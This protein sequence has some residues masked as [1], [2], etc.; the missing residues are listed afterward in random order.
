MPWPFVL[1]CIKDK[2][3]A[4]IPDT[5]PSFTRSEVLR[6]QLFWTMSF[7]FAASALAVSALVV[8]MT[9]LLHDA[10]LGMAAVAKI[11]SSI[12]LGVLGGRIVVGYLIDRFFAPYVAA[13]LFAAT[14][15]G[16]TLLLLSGVSVAPFAGMLMGLSLGAEVDLIAY[17]TSRYF[18]MRRYGFVY[19]VS[20]SIY[21]IGAS[22]GPTL[23]GI[24]FDK[25][26]SYNSVLVGATILLI[27][28]AVAML[29]MPRFE[30]ILG[31]SLVDAIEQT[32]VRA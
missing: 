10:G 32:V 21:A 27:G 8:H 19:A 11:V 17:M 9:P 25:T 2:A 3:S 18:G 26:H 16:C 28:A 14:A 12:G 15:L 13:V 7:A 5:G 4:A 30:E 20:Y 24:S 31:G 6:N 29:R 22:S 1:F 23:A